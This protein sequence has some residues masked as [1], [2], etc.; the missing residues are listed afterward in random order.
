M[1]TAAVVLWGSDS[2]QAQSDA[3]DNELYAAY[4]KGVKDQQIYGLQHTPAPTDSRQ[5]Q[6]V[7]QMRSNLIASL[8]QERRRFVEYLASTGAL[9]SPARNDAIFGLATAMKRGEADARQCGEL[10]Q[11]CLAKSNQS[12]PYFSTP[13]C[14]LVNRCDRPDNLPF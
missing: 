14:T 13:P 8:D 3:T 9:T 2:T 12:C 1:L 10:M 5:Q 7:Q 6:T 4:C 11:Q